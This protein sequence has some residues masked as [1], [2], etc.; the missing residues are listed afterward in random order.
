MENVPFIAGFIAWETALAPFAFLKQL[1]Q[2]I[3]KSNWKNLLPLVTFWL[4]FGPFI[5]FAIGILGDLLNFLRVLADYREADEEERERVETEFRKDKV[6]LYNELMD[7][8]R[9]IMHIYKKRDEEERGR[10]RKML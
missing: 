5:I 6:I 1:L 2:F 8:M 4:L 7:V 9:A 3:A 10:R